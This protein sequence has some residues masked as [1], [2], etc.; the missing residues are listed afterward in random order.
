MV[1]M[2][3]NNKTC[4]WVLLRIEKAEFRIKVNRIII[5]IILSKK[6]N[7]NQ[8]V[9]KNMNRKD[10][11]ILIP[12][13][14]PHLILLHLHLLLHNRFLLNLLNLSLKY[15]H[16]LLINPKMNLD[17][18]QQRTVRQCKEHFVLIQWVLQKQKISQISCLKINILNKLPWTI[19]TSNL[20]LQKTDA[21]PRKMS[22]KNISMVVKNR[23]RWISRKMKKT[24]ILSQFLCIIIHRTLHRRSKATM[25]CFI[26][27]QSKIKKKIMSKIAAPRIQ[28]MRSLH[29]QQ[30]PNDSF[31]ISQVVSVTIV[32][33][34]MKI[35]ETVRELTWCLSQWKAKE[36]LAHKVLACL[37]YK[38]ENPWHL[39]VP[40]QGNQEHLNSS[41]VIILKTKN[42]L[43]KSLNQCMLFTILE[44][45]SCSQ[46]TNQ[47]IE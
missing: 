13:I 25:R 38:I 17:Q 21:N 19:T 4:N 8:K 28:Q 45:Q 22:R 7:L 40:H 47:I 26:K 46:W 9:L 5:I 35:R 32:I 11:L 42:Q 34:T 3:E 43:K 37:D 1:N 23:I 27:N 12:M 31:R 30:L 2:L 10:L 14:P 18:C 41:Q 39:T 29:R 36:D 20:L 15:K 24:R 44:I 6:K 16:Y 33:V